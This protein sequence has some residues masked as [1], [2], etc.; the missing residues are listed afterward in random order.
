[1][2]GYLLKYTKNIHNKFDYHQSSFIIDY[3]FIFSCSFC[4]RVLIPT[5]PRYTIT[6]LICPA[7]TV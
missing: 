4:R 2:L 7:S 5:A 6:L 3:E 1:M